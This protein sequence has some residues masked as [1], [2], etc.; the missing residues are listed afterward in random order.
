M[1]AEALTA[2]LAALEERWAPYGGQEGMRLRAGL[3]DSAMNALVAS[4]G[5]ELDEEQRTWWGW[6]DGTEQ[7]DVY[8]YGRGQVFPSISLLPLSAAVKE[9]QFW[10][11]LGRDNP[12]L[13]PLRWLQLSDGQLPVV[14]AATGTS[15]TQVAKFHSVMGTEPRLQSL[16]H[17]VDVWLWF[18]DNSD[19]RPIKE[20]PGWTGTWPDVPL[21]LETL[22]VM[23]A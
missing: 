6:A 11:P 18:W 17:M 7:T 3:D 14:S 12:G 22:G 8:A 19:I 23:H 1:S 15:Q 5:Y 10:E 21:E 16:A 4:I 13:W 9:Y 20:A 2:R